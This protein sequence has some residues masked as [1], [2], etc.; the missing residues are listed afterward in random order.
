MNISHSLL[1]NSDH[2]TSSTIVRL[3]RVR[4]SNSNYAGWKSQH[5]FNSTMQ[6]IKNIKE[7]KD[8]KMKLLDA[9][10]S[11]E[12]VAATMKEYFRWKHNK[13]GKGI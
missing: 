11:Q 8:N 9:D 13:G 10:I 1:K 6:Y 3:T 5:I 4:S 12:Q 7:N 2:T